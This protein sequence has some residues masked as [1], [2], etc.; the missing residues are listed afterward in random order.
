MLL[1]TPFDLVSV[2]NYGCF[3]PFAEFEFCDGDNTS[4]ATLVAAKEISD[5]LGKPLFVG[6]LGAPPCLTGEFW[7]SKNC[8][9]FPKKALD[10]QVK[11]GVQLT[12]MWTWCQCPTPDPCWC[13]NNG[14]SAQPVAN[15]IAQTNALLRR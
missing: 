7:Q 15:L 4:I 9:A 3:P 6:E 2:H 13:I 14:T 5:A 10:F 11:R 8:M 12:N 1:S